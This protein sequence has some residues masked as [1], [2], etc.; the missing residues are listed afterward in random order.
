MWTQTWPLALRTSVVVVFAWGIA[1][2]LANRA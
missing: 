2:V 1:L